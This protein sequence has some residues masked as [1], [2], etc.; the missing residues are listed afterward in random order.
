MQKILVLLGLAL[1]SLPYLMG[2]LVHEMVERESVRISTENPEFKIK[3]ITHEN[4]YFSTQ[5]DF[6]VVMGK[7]KEAKTYKINFNLHHLPHFA[8]L[9]GGDI[10]FPINGAIP[11]FDYSVAIAVLSIEAGNY[12]GCIFYPKGFEASGN[13]PS[14]KDSMGLVDIEKFALEVKSSDYLY[15]KTKLS[16]GKFVANAM[17]AQVDLQD[18][19]MDL[20]IKQNPTSVD[21]DFELGLS[22]NTKLA[23]EA[24]T[25]KT[26]GKVTQIPQQ[27]SL[28]SP[29]GLKKMF[30]LKS[31]ADLEFSVSSGADSV[32]V[33]SK[34][35]LK[36]VPE[37]QTY[38]WDSVGS[39]EF[40]VS[41]AGKRGFPFK[42][43]FD[44]L[45]AHEN[46]L[47]NVYKIDLKK[48]PTTF[49][50]THFNDQYTING[51]KYFRCEAPYALLPEELAETSKEAD[52]EVLKSD[53]IEE[54]LFGDN[55]KQMSMTYCQLE[56][57]KQVKDPLNPLYHTLSD[58]ILKRFSLRFLTLPVET[59]KVL[60]PTK[61]NEELS[62][63]H[64]AYPCVAASKSKPCQSF[65]MENASTLSTHPYASMFS[66]LNKE[67]PDF[68][69]I[70]AI[71]AADGRP[72]YVKKL[73]DLT[74]LKIQ[75]DYSIRTNNAKT[76]GELI[77]KNSSLYRRAF[78]S[79]VVTRY[80]CQFKPASECIKQ[81]E[82]EPMNFQNHRM[83][84]LYLN[85]F[86]SMVKDLKGA[87]C[88]NAFNTL[89]SKVSD[90]EEDSVLRHMSNCGGGQLSVAKPEVI[91]LD[92][93]PL[94]IT[95]LD[96]LI[97]TWNY[98][99]NPAYQIII[100]K[101]GAGKLMSVI[102]NWGGNGADQAA[103]PVEYVG[104]VVLIH[105]YNGQKIKLT[106]TKSHPRRLKYSYGGHETVEYMEKAF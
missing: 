103:A 73:Y 75:L 57:L 46:Q 98:S 56:Y 53:V 97:G 25:F 77:N 23:P 91:E 74:R 14:I 80:N 5:Y 30:E 65:I 90:F 29:Q 3:I 17:L 85:K 38:K 42:F 43:L 2:I 95:N 79:S 60:L 13:F 76:A 37:E 48:T 55:L 81:M 9:A 41:E 104:N 101:N 8:R 67:S 100:S 27:F 82:M 45:S 99:V 35:S 92:P 31:V 68:V 87:E 39:A 88:E 34:S 19:L 61:E 58:L 105:Y 20:G 106:K 6:E 59:R 22:A 47:L 1:L 32:S 44:G 40:K 50:F 52:P 78:L 93:T 33:S 94:P 66:E 11:K 71:T 7:V 51:K 26:K 49:D 64:A 28:K 36:E 72:A 96:S 12:N 63:L 84:E 86:A 24:I 102:R 89:R 21:L 83:K 4:K 15:F 69:K 54:A 70:N 18:L 16:V 62:I 10:C